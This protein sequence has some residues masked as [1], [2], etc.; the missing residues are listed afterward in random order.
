M[1]RIMF[2]S[3]VVNSIK[4]RPTLRSGAL[5]A[6]YAEHQLEG[7]YSRQ[8]KR[9]CLL[10]AKDHRTL[11][12]LVCTAKTPRNATHRFAPL[13]HAPRLPGQPPAILH[14]SEKPGSVKSGY[15]FFPHALVARLVGRK[16]TAGPFVGPGGISISHWDAKSGDTWVPSTSYRLSA[17]QMAYIEELQR[18]FWEGVRYDGHGMEIQTENFNGDET[19]QVEGRPLIRRVVINELKGDL[20]KTSFSP[21]MTARERRLFLLRAAT[22]DQKLWANRRRIKVIRRKMLNAELRRIA[23]M[24]KRRIRRVSRKERRVV[25]VRVNKPRRKIKHSGQQMGSTITDMTKTKEPKPPRPSREKL[26][27]NT[28]ESEPKEA[29]KR[30]AGKK[31]EE[32]KTSKRRT[33]VAIIDI[34]RKF[35]EMMAPKRRKKVAVI[36][37]ARKSGPREPIEEEL[38]RNTTEGGS[39]N[40]R[41]RRVKRKGKRERE[42]LN[43][44]M[45]T[46]V[47]ARTLEPELLVGNAAGGRPR[48]IWKGGA[49]E[50]KKRERKS[51]NQQA[52][53]T[54]IDM[55][56]TLG[57]ELLVGNTVESEPRVI[58]NGRA[59]KGKKRE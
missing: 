5:R 38:I 14:S 25:R 13:N 48:M 3:M 51:S 34:A 10:Y 42:A 29:R 33:K 17:D 37:I 46:T 6:V 45:E 39:N 30:K 52:K 32:I 11:T 7:N 31:G 41:K 19:I 9:P 28:A 47:M 36:D 18:K 20:A 23:E 35:E 12:V 50:E 57:P 1:A 40:V 53:A 58:W 26:L 59:V 16:D 15:I 44:Q 49:R 55:V 43:Q 4:G 27:G 2:P 8:K 56:R 21:R 24:K 22:A 54:V